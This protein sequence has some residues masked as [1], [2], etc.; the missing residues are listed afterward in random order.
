MLEF[1]NLATEMNSVLQGLQDFSL[2]FADAPTLPS[3]GIPRSSKPKSF[4]ARDVQWLIDLPMK[5]QVAIAERKFEE[6]VKLFE[7]GTPMHTSFL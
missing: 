6:A 5:L 7:T 1:G 3:Y 4:L 2:R